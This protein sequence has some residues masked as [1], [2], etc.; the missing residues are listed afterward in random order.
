MSFQFDPF[1]KVRVG[2][3]VRRGHLSPNP[4]V[5]R[6]MTPYRNL[7]GQILSREFALQ[8]KLAS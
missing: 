8:S 5:L 7:I 6:W 2:V 1:P 3:H 4:A